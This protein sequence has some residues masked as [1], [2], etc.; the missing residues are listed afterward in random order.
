ML[1]KPNEISVRKLIFYLVSIMQFV[2]TVALVIVFIV[3]LTTDG[4]IEDACKK[5]S[6]DSAKTWL[7]VGFIATFI[8]DL[9]LCFCV[10]QILYYGWKE[11][12]S[13]AADRI[14]H[15]AIGGSGPQVYPNHPP[16]YGGPEPAYGTPQAGY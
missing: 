5:D 13:I 14:V 15:G 8:I 7:V 12:E 16:T 9:L 6:C 10:L 11:Q 4:W 1:V 3:M 2:G